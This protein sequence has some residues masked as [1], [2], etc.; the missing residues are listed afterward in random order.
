MF[1]T[2]SQCCRKCRS[3][4]NHHYGNCPTTSICPF[5]GDITLTREQMYD[6]VYRTHGK[7]C[8]DGHT[9]KQIDD[10]LN[11]YFK[12]QETRPMFITLY[13]ESYTHISGGNYRN[14]KTGLISHIS[15]WFANFKNKI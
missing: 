11:R 8:F 10:E 12:H 7:T 13:G 14:D 3:W 5:D 2:L 6:V 4:C 1:H 15:Q 9:P